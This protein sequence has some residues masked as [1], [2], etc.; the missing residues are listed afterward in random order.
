MLCLYVLEIMAS[1]II[2]GQG[3]LL[4]WTSDTLLNAVLNGLALTLFFDVDNYLGSASITMAGAPF[5][6]YYQPHVRLR[7][8]DLERAT[9]DARS[10]LT[11]KTQL[12]FNFST[13][14]LFGLY[15]IFHGWT[16]STYI[17]IFFNTFMY[18]N[19]MDPLNTCSWTKVWAT[20][21]AIMRK[22]L[23]AI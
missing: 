13:R 18:A 5:T 21:V 16:E 12:W 23:V 2:M 17:P 19:A 7:K 15:C 22:N 3:Y 8:G 10:I 20:Q 9:Q 4:I 6:R 11:G 1:I 14:R